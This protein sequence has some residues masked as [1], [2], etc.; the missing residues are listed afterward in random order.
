MGLFFPF[1]RLSLRGVRDSK[2]GKSASGFSSS[3]CLFESYFPYGIEFPYEGKWLV[4]GLEGPG[5]PPRKSLSLLFYEASID[6]L[7]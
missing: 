4:V 7:V 5:G 1:V 6:S 3:R 2:A